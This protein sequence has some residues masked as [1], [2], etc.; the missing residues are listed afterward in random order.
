ML[1]ALAQIKPKYTDRKVN[2][3]YATIEGD[4]F[5]TKGSLPLLLTAFTNLFDNA[6]KYSK[7]EVDVR[8]S[9]DNEAVIV[10][11]ADQGIGISEEE[12]SK[13]TEPLYRGE[14]VKEV[15]GFGIGLSV[16]AS[17]IELNG[18][19]IQFASTKGKGTTVVVKLPT[20]VNS[21]S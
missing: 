11:I 1:S 9:I 12:L 5:F 6:F 18:G 16:T 21:I 2:I 20:L 13:I 3:K 14:N 17:I 4:G 19:S 15:Q 10:E 7:D 8:F